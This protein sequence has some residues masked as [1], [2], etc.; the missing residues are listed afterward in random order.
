VTRFLEL[1]EALEGSGLVRPP[2]GLERT[3]MAAAAR[4]IQ[5]RWNEGHSMLASS[6]DLDK[7]LQAVRRTWERSG[8]F[9][10]LEPR[11]KRWSPF[12]LFYPQNRREG[13]LGA[14]GK[15]VTAFLS[16][17]EESRRLSLVFSTVRAC[18]NSYPEDLATFHEIRSTVGKLIAKDTSVRSERWRSRL[19]EFRL[20]EPDGPALLG[21]R[22]TNE[23]P[24]PLL[25]AA[26]L[27]GELRSSEFVAAAA[28]RSAD[29]IRV[30]MQSNAD[31]SER[32]AR[33]LEALCPKDR[34][35]F[36][37]L[38]PALARILL[39]PFESVDPSATNSQALVKL[40]FTTHGDPRIYPA[41][42][43]Q[44]VEQQDLE[45]MLRWLVRATFEDFLRIIGAT[46]KGSH[47]ASRRHFWGAYIEAGY[48]ADAWVV[49][50][51]S[52]RARARRSDSIA[53]GGYA[54]L[55]GPTNS[56]Q[57]VLL[58]RLGGVIVGE[59]SH[60]GACRLW[61]PSNPSAPKLY[62]ASY[63]ATQLRT[64]ASAE[65]RHSGDEQGMWQK[66]IE[67][68][69]SRWL[70]IHLPSSSFLRPRRR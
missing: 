22:L 47:W 38:L 48:V 63:D 4:G 5:E 41:A 9:D 61:R 40:F 7:V 10:E 69:L 19:S 26:G 42:N 21:A 12:V 28:L 15:V 2:A 18:L 70:G 52:A 37:Q 6:L 58:L 25:E 64:G 49:L 65:I 23:P 45:I 67:N 1:R 20:L 53:S 57:S 3:Q 13:W 31:C 27:T 68:L 34:F 11:L 59:W 39:R 36:P 24:G 29:A 56:A 62:R 44:G 60:D 66:G 32:I 14:D 33:L 51:R 43:W 35:A 55:K 54:T 46:A 50:G 16:M 30:E 8:S 17:L